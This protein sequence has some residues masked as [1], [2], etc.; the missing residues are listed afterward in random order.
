ME[1]CKEHEGYAM[2]KVGFLAEQKA[3]E[4]ELVKVEDQ[5][6]VKPQ[7]RTASAKLRPRIRV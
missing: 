4:R 3:W 7:T 5:E 1:R 2:L 6:V